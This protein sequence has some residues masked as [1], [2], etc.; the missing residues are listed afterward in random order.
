MPE[1]R[2]GH[3]GRLRAYLHGEAADFLERTVN[4]AIRDKDPTFADQARKALQPRVDAFL[5]G[6]KVGNIKRY[7]LPV[8]HPES[9]VYGGSP[10]DTFTLSAE[11]E[12][13]LT[14]DVDAPA[15]VP[16][17]A[18]RRAAGFRGPLTNG[19]GQAH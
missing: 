19:N 11:P 17:R 8:W 1:A 4:N 16:N 5:E 2:G 9:T 6:R 12:D 18:A 3:D 7:D 14:L 10:D 13:E 15:F